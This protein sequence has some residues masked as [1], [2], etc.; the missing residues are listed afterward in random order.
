MA[1]SG[2]SA[3]V[4]VLL[5]HYGRTFSDELDIDIKTNSPSALFRLLV[6]ALLF[7]TRISAR[8]AMQAA[9]ALT[10]QGW[11]TPPKMVAASWEVRTRIL[12]KSGYARYDENTSRMLG[13]TSQLILDRYNGDLRNLRETST[14][15]R[16]EERKQL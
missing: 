9:R 7:S 13:E 15:D 2:H 6:V 1:D 8:L 16:E 5:S 11:T 12:N 4:Q 3:L 14:H 10:D